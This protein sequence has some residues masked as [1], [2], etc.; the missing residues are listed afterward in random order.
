V[1]KHLNAQGRSDPRGGL[2]CFWCPNKTWTS[3]LEASH[4]LTVVESGLEMR[5]LGP[6]KIKRSRT[7]KKNKPLNITKVNSW[8][9]KNFLLCCYVVIRVQR[10][11][12]EFQM[13]LLQHFKWFKINKKVMRVESRRGEKWK[14]RILQFKTALFWLVLWLCTSKMICRAWDSAPIT[15]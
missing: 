3:P 8:T 5:K 7:H 6:L 2:S 1:T 13:A 14:K 12:L 9:P 4:T 11:F 15:F 10:W